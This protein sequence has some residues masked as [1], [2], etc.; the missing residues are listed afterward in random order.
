[1]DKFKIQNSKFKINPKP[2]IAKLSIKKFCL[3]IIGSLVIILNF[4]L[5]YWDLT[6][7]QDK[8]IAVV[9]NDII[10]RK[11]LDNFVNFMR[12]QLSQDSSGQELQRKIESMK[13]DLIDKLIEDRLILQEA[14]KVLEEARQNKNRLILRRLEVDP[15]RIKSRI[16]EMRSRYGSEAGFQDALARQ[17]LTQADIELKIEEQSLMYNIIELKIKDKI[18]INPIE[19]TEFYQKNPDKFFTPLEREVTVVTLDNKKPA[20]EVSAELSQNQDLDALAAKYGLKIERLSFQENRELREDIEA[21][22]SKLEIGQISAPI[23]VN[24]NL[25]IFRLD[26]IIM[27]KQEALS[28]AQDGIRAFLFD[29]K[30]KRD[31][32][33]WLGELKKKA[34]IKIAQN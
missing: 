19:V 9:N 5:G 24:D 27:P 12:M 11:D 25:Y 34:Y 29:G 31:L 21:A 22:I 33:A 17:G 4:V 3:L 2:Q 16:N 1:M 32:I 6:F 26:N 10:T 23:R 20:E 18:V 15:D 7:A 8:I 13:P 30:I 28:Q 14:K